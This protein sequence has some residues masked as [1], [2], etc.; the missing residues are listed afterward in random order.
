MFMSGSPPI[1]GFCP[2]VLVRDMGAVTVAQWQSIHETQGSILR[3]TPKQTKHPFSGLL[4]PTHGQKGR[5]VS[6]R[7]ASAISS[8]ASQLSSLSLGLG[9]MLDEFLSNRCHIPRVGTEVR[10]AGFC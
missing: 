9:A 4:E 3:T 10:R 1:L 8:P 6:P 2:H 7:E 5:L